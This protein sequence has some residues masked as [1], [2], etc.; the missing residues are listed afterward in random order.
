MKHFAKFRPL[1]CRK[2]GHKKF[3]EKSSTFSTRNETKFFHRK[4][5]G[6]GA[7][8][9]SRRSFQNE[10]RLKFR[11]LQTCPNSHLPARDASKDQNKNAQIRALTSSS[12]N[13]KQELTY[14]NSRPLMEETPVE[15]LH[16][17]G[18][19]NSGRFGVRWSFLLTA[20]SFYLQL[21]I[22]TK[23]ESTVSKKDE[24]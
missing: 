10:M 9:F 24:P 7:P 4:I 8:R 23:G 2:S 18:G 21:V 22:V 5:L 16:A 3:H 19:A 14:T 20:R 12:V 17:A 11:E 13:S 6:V 15:D 1:I